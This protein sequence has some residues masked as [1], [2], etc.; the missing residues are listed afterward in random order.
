MLPQVRLRRGGPAHG[1]DQRRRVPRLHAG[2][3]RHL[4]VQG[5][6]REG[7]ALH[8]AAARAAG[9]LVEIT[10]QDVKYNF[11]V[12]P[13]APDVFLF[14]QGEQQILVRPVTN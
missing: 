12:T 9:P 14:E 3:G 11:K 10:Y 5:Q 13:K 8:S 1:G 6:P 2:P 7:P 4:V